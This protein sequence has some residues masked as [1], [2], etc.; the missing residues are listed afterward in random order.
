MAGGEKVRFR[1]SQ[2]LLF[3]QEEELGKNPDSL[4][5]LPKFQNGGL[6]EFRRWVMETVKFP[7]EALESGVEGRVLASFVVEADGSVGSVRIIR[8][9]HPVLSRKVVRALA[10]SPRW[11]PGSQNG[12]PVRV[13]YTV[14][15]D[16]RIPA[17]RKTASG[18]AQERNT[19]RR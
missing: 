9:P 5:V 4:D 12:E 19:T 18:P 7:R 11:T 14:P 2:I 10:E 8:S 1:I 3:G 17:E 13:K 15:V 16:F 6:P